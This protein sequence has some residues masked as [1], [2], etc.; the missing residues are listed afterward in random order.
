MVT[1]TIPTAEHSAGQHDSI[2]IELGQP[3]L[4]ALLAWLVPGLGHLY[5]GRT[6]K[7]LLFLVCILGTFLYGLYLGG[8]KVVYASSTSVL[9]RNFWDRWQYGCQAGVGL[10]SWPAYLQAVRVKNHKEPMWKGEEW[11]DNGF[12][13]PPRPGNVP[14]EDASKNTS[15]QP[16]E[17]AL[18]NVK[19]HPYFE[20]GTV[21]TVIAGLL[22]LLVIC[23]AF[24]GPLVIA[25]HDDKK[26][27]Q[28]KDPA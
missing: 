1:T 2:E 14:L 4:A 13:A 9:D 22:N 3:W 6:G 16:S 18:W 28:N 17:L 19:L 21:Y 11:F 8:G 27:K 20:L 15:I 7:G 25:P 26:N 23:D 12:M 24:A 5:Q 10:A